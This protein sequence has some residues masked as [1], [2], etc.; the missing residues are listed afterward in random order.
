MDGVLENFE[1]HVGRATDMFLTILE[2]IALP[3][4]S[5][6]C[7]CPLQ[8]LPSARFGHWRPPADRPIL[9]DPVDMYTYANY[10]FENENGKSK[11]AALAFSISLLRVTFLPNMNRS[12]EHCTSQLLHIEVHSRLLSRDSCYNRLCNNR[13]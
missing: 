9:T 6:H 11:I 5:S 13:Q 4:H 8:L 7:Q 12:S 2:A 1:K 3:E 10:T